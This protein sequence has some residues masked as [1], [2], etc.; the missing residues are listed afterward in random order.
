MQQ[1][2]ARVDGIE[3]RWLERGLGAAVVFVHGIPTCPELWRHV[4]PLL[5]G[6]IRL[7]HDDSARAKESFREHWRGYD[8]PDGAGAF[9]RQVRSLRTEDTLAIAERLK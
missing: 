8:H 2:N 1:R 7:G 4:L 5:Q 6:F 3:M 9:M